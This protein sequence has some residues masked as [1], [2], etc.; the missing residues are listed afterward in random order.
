MAD[1]LIVTRIRGGIG[2]Q[3]FIYAMARRLSF[4]NDIPLNFDIVSGFKKDG[5]N[6][7]YLLGNFNIKAGMAT[8]YNSFEDAF[9]IFR[10]IFWIKACRF[11]YI[12]NRFYVLENFKG[13]DRSILDLEIRKTVYIDGLWQS[14]KYFKDIEHIL[15]KDFKFVCPFDSATAK[16]ADEIQNVNAVSLHWRS[17]REVPPEDGSPALSVDYYNKAI[18]IIAKKVED[19][20]FFCFSD[21]LE[22]LKANLNINYP[23]TYVSNN[24]GIKGD[25]AINDLYL[26]SQCKYHIIANSTFSWWGAWLNKNPNKVVVAPICEWQNPDYIPSCWIWDC[27]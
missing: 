7:K 25:G 18:D 13:F 9:G 4:I 20:H 24:S 6:R 27:I 17:Y 1:K 5:Y 11:K 14:E 26:M 15:R 19:P 16:M 12:N 3:L 2:N 21:N 10:R 22:W 8:K 23:V